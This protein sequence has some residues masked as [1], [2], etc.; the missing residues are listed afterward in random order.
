MVDAGVLSKETYPSDE[1]RKRLTTLN[2]NPN[3]KTTTSDRTNF[4]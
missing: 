2:A 1:K 4:A 3:G